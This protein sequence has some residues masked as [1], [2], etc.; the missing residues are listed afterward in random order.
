M[1]YLLDLSYINEMLKNKIM[2]QY[3]NIKINIKNIT[4]M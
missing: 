4:Y 1:F 3:N 2:K